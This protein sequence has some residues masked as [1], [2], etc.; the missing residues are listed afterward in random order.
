MTKK[1]ISQL[2]VGSTQK[3][4]REETKAIKASLKGNWFILQLGEV[5]CK[6]GVDS[7][8]LD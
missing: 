2:V 4:P 3:V 6:Q 8:K 5:Q 7:N 1:P